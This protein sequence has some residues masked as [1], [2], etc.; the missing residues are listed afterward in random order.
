MAVERNPVDTPHSMLLFFASNGGEKKGE[1]TEPETKTKEKNIPFLCLFLYIFSPTCLF[2]TFLILFHLLRL[3][4]DFRKIQHGIMWW[5]G[6]TGF[7]CN[8]YKALI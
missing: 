4:Q 3:G 7:I 5:Y 2:M 1:K 6:N 8:E